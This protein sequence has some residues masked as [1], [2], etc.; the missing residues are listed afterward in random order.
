[1]QSLEA[2]AEISDFVAGLVQRVPKK[3]SIAKSD[4]LNSTARLWKQ[5]A[6]ATNPN[7]MLYFPTASPDFDFLYAKLKIYLKIKHNTNFVNIILNYA[8]TNPMQLT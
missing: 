7:Q 3:T 2:L 4:L 8:T 6:S 5:I 1:M